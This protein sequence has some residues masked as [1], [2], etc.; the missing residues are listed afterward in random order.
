[1]TEF[2]IDSKMLPDKTSTSNNNKCNVASSL[3]MIHARLGH[4]S[5]SKMQHLSICDCTGLKEYNCNICLYFNQHKLPFSVS[6]SRANECFRLIHL[7]L[8]GP[9]KVKALNG[10]S[11]FHTVLDDHSRVVWTFLLHNKSQVSK[12]IANFLALI[13]T[14]F[15]KPVKGLRSTN[16]T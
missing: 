13:E 10:A 1:M 11:Y 3:H 6:I 16:E 9:Y 2:S 14:R 15:K 4:V 7:D 12:T 5:L 8:W